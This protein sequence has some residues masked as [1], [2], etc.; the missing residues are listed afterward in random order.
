MHQ[1]HNFDMLKLPDNLPKISRYWL[2][3][4]VWSLAI[5]GLFSLV[6]VVARTPSLA[7]MPLFAQLFHSALVVHV[8]LSVLLWFLSIACMFWSVQAN[9]T[10][11]FF[12]YI[13]EAAQ[14]C[15]VLGILLIAAAPFDQSSAPLMSNYIPV[16]TSPI[17]FLGL[18][19]VMCG[20]GLMIARLFISPTINFSVH[21]SAIITLLA[22]V[23]FVRSFQIMP[24][25]INGQQYYELAFWGGGH[26]LQ[27]TH[28]QILLICWL[29]LASSVMPAKAGIQS[30]FAYDKSIFSIG[31][32]AAAI[33]IIPYFLYEITSMEYREFFTNLMIIGGGIAPL[34]LAPFIAKMIWKQRKQKSAI[35][36]SLFM[37]L[38]LFLYGGLL[39]GM[40]RGQ[41]VVIP[42][43]YH[44]SIV[45]ITLAFMGVAYLLLPRFGYRDVS[46]WRLAFWQ[47]FV[48]GGGQ[49]LHISGLAWSG[50]YGVLRKTTWNANGTENE[51]SISVKAALGIMGLGGLLAIIGGFMFVVVIWRSVRQRES[52]Q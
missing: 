28:T 49:L 12:P 2:L 26:I 11:C 47:P 39:A 30:F 8:D 34:I 43:H 22:I 50:G 48:Y 20:V 32:I 35:L 4:G 5:A 45:G 31:V 19:M 6:L 10:A 38:L 9:K 27:F 18:S 46:K 17:F 1:N 25:E 44:G 42:A 23:A 52:I 41:N 21:S 13:E 15:F 40:I 29:L 33:G 7:S 16:I 24:P 37:S 36:S 3:I 51:V 14:I